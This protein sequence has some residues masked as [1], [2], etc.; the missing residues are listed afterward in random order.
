[1]NNEKLAQFA[2]TDYWKMM[3]KILNDKAEA[4]YGWESAKNLDEAKGVHSFK[5]MI[6]REIEGA[7]DLIKDEK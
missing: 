2:V 1:M 4:H 5:R 6:E 3:K 7:K